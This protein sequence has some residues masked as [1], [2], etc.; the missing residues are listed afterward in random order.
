MYLFP[1]RFFVLSRTFWIL[2]MAGC[3][4]LPRAAYSRAPAVA[5]TPAEAG[6]PPECGIASWHEPA[7]R[8][9]AGHTASRRPWVGTE[10]VAAHKTL[11][12]GTRVRVFN[13]SNGREVVVVITDRGPYRRGR[14]IDVSRSAAQQLGLIHAGTAR[15][16]LQALLP[17]AS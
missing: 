2:A 9:S 12:L 4:L 14:I 8:A 3:S 15:V 11:P 17:G 13:L 10:L 6:K 7:S 5:A 1:R 16:R